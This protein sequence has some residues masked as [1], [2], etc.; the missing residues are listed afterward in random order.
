VR[1]RPG[2]AIVRREV[3]RGLPWM[4][5]IVF[6]VEDGD[7][8]LATYLPEGASF[9]FPDGDW[10]GGRHPWHGRG[11]WAGHGVL[12]LHRPGD[13]YSVWHF[14]SGPERRFSAWYLNLQD[15]F[16]RTSVGFDTADHELDVIV[17]PDGSWEFKDD[18]LLE[19]RVAD[20]RYTP[21]EVAEI[22]AE[23][24]RIAAD[25]DAGRRWWDDGWT[26]WSP[27]PA[28]RV[29]ELPAGWAEAR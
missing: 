27:D 17:R 19:Q 20:G 6:V 2:E 9:G 23:G 16:V 18:E 8:L 5:S 21:A 3:W 29:P 25:L 24:A 4:G 7:A 10:P 28:W 26:S 22:R 12:M 11:T 14:W 13:A 1:W 15:P